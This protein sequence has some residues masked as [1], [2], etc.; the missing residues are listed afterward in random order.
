MQ[1]VSLCFIFGLLEVISNNSFVQFH[2]EERLCL[3]LCLC[4]HCVSAQREAKF[5]RYELKICSQER[6]VSLRT[7]GI[8]IKSGFS[9]ITVRC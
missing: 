7:Q 1:L 9:I 2:T 3:Q 4:I 5:C 6:K 8:Q